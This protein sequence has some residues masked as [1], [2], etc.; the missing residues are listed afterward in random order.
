MKITC[1]CGV[2]L[3]IGY[4][5]NSPTLKHPLPMCNEFSSE[6]ENRD[7]YNR[8]FIH[9]H[10]TKLTKSNLPP[11]KLPLIYSFPHVKTE[12]AEY[13]TMRLLNMVANKTIDNPTL[14]VSSCNALS[15]TLDALL[16]NVKT[17][18]HKEIL[19]DLEEHLKLMA[20]AIDD[21]LWTIDNPEKDEPYNS[22][23]PP[24]PRQ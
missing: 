8:N 22:N 14:T 12:D 21:G 19:R 5:W 2:T 9:E 15:Y 4:E 1:S 7:Y 20:Q 17:N 24:S 16:T 23:H 10:I 3:T 18:E 13:A 6:G 11:S